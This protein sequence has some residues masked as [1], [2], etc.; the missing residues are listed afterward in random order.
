MLLSR[1]GYPLVGVFI[2]TKLPGIGGVLFFLH[3]EGEL[4][5]LGKGD[6]CGGLSGV[7]HGM[8]PLRRLRDQGKPAQLGRR[9]ERGKAKQQHNPFW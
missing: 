1:N 9:K 7:K 5:I 3:G 8:L 2:S 4:V 6:A